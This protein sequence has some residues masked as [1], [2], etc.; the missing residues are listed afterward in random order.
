MSKS[1]DVQK[2]KLKFPPVCVACMSPAAKAYQVEKVFTFGK[3]SYTVGVAVPM[4]DLHYGF[5]NETSKA[6]RLVGR[7]G[8]IV[9]LMVW[10]ITSG[11]LLVYWAGT[12]QGNLVLN[13][14]SA[15][16]LGCGLFL[17]V[18]AATTFWLAPYFASGDSKQARNAVRLTHYWPRDELIRLDFENEQLAEIVERE[19]IIRNL[20]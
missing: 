16:V 2:S 6:E 17:I 11:A 5:A 3:A 4:C 20:P 10:M 18:W 13:L 1:I 15:G 19:S 9:G 14:F 8:M 7:L 12:E